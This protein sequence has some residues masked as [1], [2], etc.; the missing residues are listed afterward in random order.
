MN[1]SATLMLVA[2]LAAAAAA[3]TPMLSPLLPTASPSQTA[4]GN[5]AMSVQAVTLGGARTM[6]F[7]ARDGS[8]IYVARIVLRNTGT[9]AASLV[10]TVVVQQADGAAWQGAAVTAPSCLPLSIAETAIVEVELTLPDPRPSRL[11]AAGVLELRQSAMPC[12]PGKPMPAAAVPPRIVVRHDF[13]VP[14]AARALGA[15]VGSSFVAV[16]IIGVITAINL[17]RRGVHLTRAMGVAHW[18]FDRSWGANVTLGSA[19]LV[20]VLGLTLFPEQPRFM[21]KV[22][23]SSLQVLFGALVAT[24]PLVYNLI[25]RQVEVNENGNTRVVVHGYVIM[26]LVSGALVLW[27]ALGQIATLWLL[28]GELE[29]GFAID[30]TA[31]RTLRL[32]LVFL[33]LVVVVYGF[34]SLYRTPKL[35]SAA[36]GTTTFKQPGPQPAEATTLSP[37]LTQWS[38]L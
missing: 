11:P 30:S 35:V 3:I 10:P 38:I 37:Q 16:L 31:S 22:S 17:V 33:G 7:Q 34:R 2:M 29:H 26:F 19:L 24:A 4:S 25:H 6:M 5:S 36:A 1:T 27:A 21:S 23:Y 18:S 13:R 9:V 20:A 15:V 8:I 32:L 28:V 12:E 14:G